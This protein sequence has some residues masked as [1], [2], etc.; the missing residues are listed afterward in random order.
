MYIRS[1]EMQ[2]QADRG[3]EL[4]M[5]W[6]SKLNY[7]QSKCPQEAAEFKVLL[8]GGM[9]PGWENALPV[10]SSCLQRDSLFIISS[11]F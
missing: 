7:Y 6:H 9:L 10:M 5:D 1:R 11:L 3:E 4:E 8:S 2:V